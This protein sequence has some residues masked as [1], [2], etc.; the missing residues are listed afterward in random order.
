MPLN[1]VAIGEAMHEFHRQGQ[2][3]RKT[4]NLA[5]GGDTLNFAVYAARLNQQY[6]RIAYATALGDDHLSADLVNLIEQESVDTSLI[7]Q[8]HQSSTGCY[9][10][11]NDE[12]GEKNIQ[13]LA[14]R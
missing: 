12:N 6:H 10:I 13:L 14:L 3:P 4:F 9:V 7:Y 2:H 8:E 1:I 11:D 5:V